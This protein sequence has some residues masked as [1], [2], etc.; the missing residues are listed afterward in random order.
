M[1]VSV[2]ICPAVLFYLCLQRVKTLS[3]IRWIQVDLDKDH[4]L[5]FYAQR[6]TLKLEI[7]RAADCVE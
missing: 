7:V 3:T 1:G 5:N 4:L 6:N 2:K